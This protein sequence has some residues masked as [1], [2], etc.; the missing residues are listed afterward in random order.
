MGHN[1]RHFDL[2]RWSVLCAAASA[3]VLEPQFARAGDGL[4]KEKGYAQSTS[5][6]ERVMP[7]NAKPPIVAPRPDPPPA[8]Q[9]VT[10][11]AIPPGAV[12]PSQ[13]SPAIRDDRRIPIRLDSQAVLGLNSNLVLDPARGEFERKEPPFERNALR[14]DR[15]LDFARPDLDQGAERGRKK[16]SLLPPGRSG[17]FGEHV[18]I[19]LNDG[20]SY[21]T[22]FEVNDTNLR[23]KLYG[24]MVKG[25]PGAGARLRGM[26]LDDHP[27]EIRARATKQLQDVQIKIEF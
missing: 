22:N 27:V 2:Q 25:N 24:P 18:D 19:D 21:R 9:D 6:L 16:P 17:W 26:K 7:A 10:P 12:R 11:L 1:A 20:V 3:L 8:R 13:D 4:S 23:L 14:R 5:T 15:Q